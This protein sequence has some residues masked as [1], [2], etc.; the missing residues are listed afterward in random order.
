[1]EGAVKGNN[2]KGV[3]ILISDRT[4][5]NAKNIMYQTCHEKNFT[6]LHYASETDSDKIGELL[7]SKGALIDVKDIIY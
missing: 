4:D 5:I 6:P 7:I 2:L 3:F 1:M